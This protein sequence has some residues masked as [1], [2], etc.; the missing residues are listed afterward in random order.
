MLGNYGH[1]NG[2]RYHNLVLYQRVINGKANT[3]KVGDRVQT[4]E[5]WKDYDETVLVLRNTPGTIIEIKDEMFLVEL[6]ACNKRLGGNRI[7]FNGWEI[8]QIPR[9][10]KTRYIFEGKGEPTP[11]EQE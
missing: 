1:N 4:L 9:C 3:M 5:D 10:V 7:L 11:F 6:D 8:E 2:Y